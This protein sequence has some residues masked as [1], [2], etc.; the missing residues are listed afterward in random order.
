[1]RN[2]ILYSLLCILVLYVSEKVLEL[3]Y[4]VKTLV[5]L[6]LFTLVPAMSLFTIKSKLKA[7]NFKNTLLTAGGVFT[8][9]IV[10]FLFVNRYI[11]FTIIQEDFTS[12][13]N[14]S[15]SMFIFAGLYTI[16]INALIEELFFRGYIFL[17]MSRIN[18]RMA[19]LFSAALFAVYH[20]TIF[21]AWFTLPILTLVLLGLFVGG[22]I[23][24]YF[25]EKSKSILT[26]YIIHIA[27]D[28][29]VVVIGYQVLYIA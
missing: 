10:A 3:P 23:F 17:N 18:R 25:A 9:I 12:R 13:L 28:M 7:N 26:P 4:I 14:I 2:I 29:A 20:L 22:L 11:D 21:K 5:K 15:K 16:F 27:A 24:N 6:P 1:M 19:Y 8:I